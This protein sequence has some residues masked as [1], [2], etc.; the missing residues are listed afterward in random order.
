VSTTTATT[1]LLS[2]IDRMD[3]KAFVSH[4][5][6]DCVFR[7]A[8]QD[9]VVGRDAIEEAV[10]GFFGTIRGLRHELFQEWTVDDTTILRFDVTY[11]RTD[12]GEVTVPAAAIQRRDA[13][14]LIDDYRIFNDLTPVYA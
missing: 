3:A 4:L 12:G 6:E 14:G 13:D 10:A 9:E 8:N 1:E 11:T 2:D 7:Y 5:S